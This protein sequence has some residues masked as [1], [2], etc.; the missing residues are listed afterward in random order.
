[1]IGDFVATYVCTLYSAKKDA[2]SATM[3]GIGAL[4]VTASRGYT[5]KSS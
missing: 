5:R 2:A 4:S 1:M 3:A